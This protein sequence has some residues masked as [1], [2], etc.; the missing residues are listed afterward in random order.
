MLLC[1]ENPEEEFSATV[2]KGPIAVA[3]ATAV[4]QVW[5]LA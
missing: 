2:G 1:T 4:M 5:S 3:W